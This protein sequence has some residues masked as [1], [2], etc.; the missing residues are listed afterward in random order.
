MGRLDHW[1][2]KIEL[3]EPGRP[4]SIAVGL[5]RWVVGPFVRI[6]WRPRLEGVERLPH[7][8]PF[9]LVSNHSGGM[10]TA[11][12]L[13]FAVCYLG[14]FGT[15]RPLAGFGHPLAFRYQPLKMLMEG[16]GAVPSTYQHAES[17]LAAGVPLLIFPGGDYEA[18]RPIWQAGLVDF[19][20]R[21][22]FL[23]IAEQ[24]D[25][26]IVP[27]GISGSH[28]TTPV[29]WRSEK[30]LPN[31]LLLPR[32]LLGLKR[33]PLTLLSLVGA[34]LILLAAPWSWPA[35]V[36]V[37]WVWLATPFIF[38]PFVPST[39]R[40]RIGTPLEP[41]ELFDAAEETGMLEHAYERVESAV[42]NLVKPTIN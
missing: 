41:E 20:G 6:Y 23:R 26:P 30:I 34:L 31:M 39:I 36:A 35:K 38:L 11:E 5:F 42:Q 32:F 3:T 17:T 27:M 29:L 13:S 9:L 2:E 33:W 37:A 14:Q 24:A 4:S 18:T 8:R 12:I 25:V 28:V 15:D 16:L 40:M 7:A 22:G 21:K 19:N 1:T 10:A